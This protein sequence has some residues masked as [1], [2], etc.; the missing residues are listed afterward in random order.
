MTMHGFRDDT[1]VPEIL[2]LETLRYRS[3]DAHWRHGERVK[4]RGY[5]P[6]AKCILRVT[7]GERVTEYE[8][9]RGTI[10]DESER[11]LRTDLNEVQLW[12]KKGQ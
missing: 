12:T 9:K 6:L 3:N 11:M 4:M 1:P 7:Q 5:N 10:T 8:V 2:N